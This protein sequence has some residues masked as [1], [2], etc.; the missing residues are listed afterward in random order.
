MLR[1]V[2]ATGPYTSSAAC[3]TG[4][5]LLLKRSSPTCKAGPCSARRAQCVGG[6][7]TWR[8]QL[9]G[10]FCT[11]QDKAAVRSSSF[12]AESVIFQGLRQKWCKNVK[13]FFCFWRYRRRTNAQRWMEAR[14]TYREVNSP[15]SEGNMGSAPGQE[16]PMLQSHAAWKPVRHNCGKRSSEACTQESS[17]TRAQLREAC[18]ATS[19]Q[20][21]QE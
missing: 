4:R 14:C 10:G 5:C 20:R 9:S 12:L 13:L 11:A 19:V 1:E 18:S 21:S 2:R 7:H 3:I 6:T 15:V 8:P 16:D 17:P